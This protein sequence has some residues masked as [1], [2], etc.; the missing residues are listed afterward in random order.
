MSQQDT[1]DVP[2]GRSRAAHIVGTIKGWIETIAIGGLAFLAIQHLL[3]AADQPHDEFTKLFALFF[4]T[5]FIINHGTVM[6]GGFML[7]KSS[8]V[9]RGTTLAFLIPIYALFAVA[10]GAAFE[11]WWVPILILGQIARGAL[12]LG[13]DAAV[14]RLALTFAATVFIPTLLAIALTGLSGEEFQGF[15][16]PLWAVLYFG[17]YTMVVSPPFNAWVD[18]KMKDT[19][20]DARATRRWRMR[21]PKEWARTGLPNAAVVIEGI[22]SEDADDDGAGPDASAGVAAVDG[23]RGATL[24]AASTS[25]AS[26]PDTPARE[27]TSENATRVIPAPR[28]VAHDPTELEPPGSAV[29]LLRRDEDFVIAMHSRIGDT[30]GVR[31]AFAAALAVFG[32]MVLAMGGIPLEVGAQ[33]LAAAE[34]LGSTLF[35]SG[36]LL[37]GLVFAGGAVFV[38]AVGVAGVFMRREV[39][40]GPQRCYSLDALGPF[41]RRRHFQLR[42]IVGVSAFKQRCRI[43]LADRD[44]LIDIKGKAGRDWLARV[45]ATARHGAR[46]ATNLE[47]TPSW[48][49]GQRA[50]AAAVLVVVVGGLTTKI[51][52]D[53]AAPFNEDGDNARWGLDIAHSTVDNDTNRNAANNA[54]NDGDV[55][56]RPRRPPYSIMQIAAPDRPITALAVDEDAGLLVSASGRTLAG[57]ALVDDAPKVHTSPNWRRTATAG[58][59]TQLRISAKAEQVVCVG[60]RGLLELRALDTGDIVATTHH[61]EE[62]TAI[63]F[64]NQGNL[65]A[66]GDAVGGVRLLNTADLSLVRAFE[67]GPDVHERST[68]AQRRD[69][70]PLGPI[71]VV[72]FSPAD[73][74]IA[75]GGS[76]HVRFWRTANAELLGTAETG[77][78]PMLVA[79]YTREP[80]I[81]RIA[82][83][84][85]QGGYYGAWT[86]FGENMTLETFDMGL[87]RHG[88]QAD[89][90]IFDATAQQAAGWHPDGYVGVWGVGGNGLRIRIAQ[91]TA[92]DALPVLAFSRTGYHLASGDA[93]GTIWVWYTRQ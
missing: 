24:P 7:D 62:I 23:T 76:G 69:A 43:H 74:A 25:A 5:D 39:L 50:L 90:L 82:V 63:A 84:E 31:L 58:A 11:T 79:F 37:V 44:I 42:D 78:R 34:G 47:P 28:L 54:T 83:R 56:D 4:V 30:V 8:K 49:I 61:D 89:T 59:I 26:T 55:P 2:H 13:N 38:I 10:F 41:G 66:I 3:G 88:A 45:I 70:R 14:G 9:N 1:P 32:G 29:R 71:S 22:A 86:V 53:I 16:G 68:E 77:G 21:N 35:G 85:P 6:I 64:S 15:D 46:R 48:G 51:V 73:D 36:L 52:L 65:V 17:F 57:W 12:S 72:A 19:S 60:E 75:A 93:T 80:R 81:T 27:R 20:A 67:A 40:L 87:F 92:G 91:H 18:R 33:L